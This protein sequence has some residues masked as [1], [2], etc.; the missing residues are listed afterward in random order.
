MDLTHFPWLSTSILFPIA[1][2]LLLP[3]IPDKDGRTV[4]WY[5]LIVGLLDFALLVYAF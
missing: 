1:A 5:A 4:G 2:A 3:I